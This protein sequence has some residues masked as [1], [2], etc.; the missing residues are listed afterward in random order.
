MAT[1]NFT[2]YLKTLEIFPIKNLDTFIF[3]IVNNIKGDAKTFTLLVY[4]GLGLL[5]M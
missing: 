1:N 2:G 5:V 4:I 3:R